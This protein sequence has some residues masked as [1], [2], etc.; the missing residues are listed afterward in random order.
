MTFVGDLF[1]SSTATVGFP[2]FAAFGVSSR[3]RNLAIQSCSAVRFEEPH[4]DSW[5]SSWNRGFHEFPTFL[6]MRLIKVA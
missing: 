5:F 2:F 4:L 3:L 1:L 6:H